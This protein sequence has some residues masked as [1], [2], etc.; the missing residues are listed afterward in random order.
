M[1]QTRKYVQAK[2]RLTFPHN[3]QEELY[4]ELNRLGWYWQPKKQVW[5]RDDT[6]AREANKLI[7]IRLWASGQQVDGIA[8]LLIEASET[9]GLKLIEK[10]N[11]YPC[12][13]PLQKESR[14]YLVFEQEK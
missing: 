7:K 3:S 5:E 4:S 9:I 11:P 1:K 10:S 13:P 12:R 8:D 6:P 2:E 14:V